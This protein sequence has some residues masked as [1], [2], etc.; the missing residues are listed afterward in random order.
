MYGQQGD[1]DIAAYRVRVAPI[2]D[3]SGQILRNRLQDILA[4]SRVRPNAREYILHVHLSESLKEIGTRD[5]YE[6]RAHLRITSQWQLFYAGQ[7]KIFA[8]GTFSEGG[9][10]D[11]IVNDYANL[12]AKRSLRKKILK[13]MAELIVRNV[14]AVIQRRQSGR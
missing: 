11:I 9:S 12:T 7:K 6:T 14:H 3:H 4:V 5:A 13:R 1:R 10:Y 2:L 8:Q